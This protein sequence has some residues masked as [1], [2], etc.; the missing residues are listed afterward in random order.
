MDPKSPS[1]RH[2]TNVEEE[3]SPL[4]LLAFPSNQPMA[5]SYPED[6]AYEAEEDTEYPAAEEMEEEEE[7]DGGAEVEETKRIPINLHG[8]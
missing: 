8:H 6:I 3:E 2:P 5:D 7:Q 4:Q 1:S